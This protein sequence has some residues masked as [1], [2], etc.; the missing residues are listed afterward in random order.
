[1]TLEKRVAALEAKA[2]KPGG[3]VVLFQEGGLTYASSRDG[4]GRATEPLTAEEEA[5]LCAGAETV[6]RVCY[7]DNWRAGDGQEHSDAA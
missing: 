3:F 7:I 1:M 6:I 2:A 5:A 4:N